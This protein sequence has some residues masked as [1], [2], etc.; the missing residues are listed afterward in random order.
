MIGARVARGTT[1]QGEEP[2]IRLGEVWHRRRAGDSAGQRTSRENG[3][4]PACLGRYVCTGF[5]HLPPRG[6]PRA[7]PT[8]HTEHEGNTQRATGAKARGY[9]AGDGDG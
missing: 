4:L 3:K 6:T 1:M 9:D 8:P 5:R 2:F 7:T